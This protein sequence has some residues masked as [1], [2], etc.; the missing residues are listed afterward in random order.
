M[1]GHSPAELEFTYFKILSPSRNIF[2]SSFLFIKDMI[3]LLVLMLFQ[4]S[5]GA[6][7]DYFSASEFR[8]TRRTVRRTKQKYVLSCRMSPR[9]SRGNP[10]NRS[11]QDG[12]GGWF[13]I[14]K[15]IGQRAG[16]CAKIPGRALG[17]FGISKM[18]CSCP[19]VVHG[20]EVG[21]KFYHEN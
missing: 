13:S 11:C 7:I 18:S 9:F 16:F 10:I 8:R 1:T 4:Q 3:C 5:R 12:S 15:F 21:S 2:S 19:A 6:P 17:D 14:I 20:N